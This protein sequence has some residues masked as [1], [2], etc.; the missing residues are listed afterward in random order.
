MNSVA[1]N[2]SA[3]ISWTGHHQSGYPRGGGPTASGWEDC[4]SGE[5]TTHVSWKPGEPFM[6]SMNCAALM[7]IMGN[8]DGW[9]AW[10]CASRY[11]CVCERVDGLVGP[12]SEYVAFTAAQQ[13]KLT[14]WVCIQVLILI[15]LLL[16]LPLMIMRCCRY[17]NKKTSTD[18]RADANSSSGD[19]SSATLI[20]AERDAAFLRARVSNSMSLVGWFIFVL[21]ISAVCTFVLS[22]TGPAVGV[23]TNYITC[24]P[25][26]MALLIL[27]L[28]PTEDARITAACG[29][30]FGLIIFLSFALVLFGLVNLLFDPNNPNSIGT[31]I[32]MSTGALMFLS[33]D[34]ILV[35][36]LCCCQKQMAPRR[37]L[38]RLWIAAR[39]FMFLLSLGVSLPWIMGILSGDDVGHIFLV[40]TSEPFSCGI[41]FSAWAGY[42]AV[43]FTT[44]S[45]RG[46]VHRWLGG[47]GKSGLQ[48]QEAACIASMIGGNAGGG[49]ASAM[50][51]AK[52]MFRA[53]PVALLTE[54]EL[55]DNK[56]NPELSKKT[57]SAT[58]GRVSA[59][60]SH[61]WSDG[62]G[63]KYQRLQEYSANRESCHI[64]LE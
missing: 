59:F 6:N 47:L 39:L 12:S 40:V 43:V 5:A 10:S 24:L 64:W 11:K 22:D 26:G 62:G 13:E 34:A 15:P 53:L 9:V 45:V 55:V 19:E 63:A 17:C 48:Q 38:Q 58:L 27:S 2:A 23:V 35:Q 52:G 16:L 60:C 18:A 21:G 57:E 44:P 14:M 25:W 28:R 1:R 46:F 31:T 20:A 8:S 41:F 42:A 61:S 50:S 7:P 3:F 33:I 56:P 32:T 29:C 37:K 49:A 30:V 51:K 54:E 4:P 36:T